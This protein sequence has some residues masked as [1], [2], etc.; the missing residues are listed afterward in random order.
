MTF[1]K[2]VFETEILTLNVPELLAACA[3]VGCSGGK[4]KLARNSDAHRS[5]RLLRPRRERPRRRRAAE[6]RDELAPSSFDHLVGAGEQRRRHVEAERL[7]G[8]EVDDQLVLGRRLHRQVGRLL[9]L[10][11]AIDV[12]G[13]APVLIGQIG[14]I[15]DQAADLRQKRARSRPRAA[16]AG[17]PAR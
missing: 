8:L 6:Q 14:P 3:K 7:G 1:C 15:G 10:E 12:A 4:G 9:A 13:R 11:D 5:G 2:A 16:C 17:P